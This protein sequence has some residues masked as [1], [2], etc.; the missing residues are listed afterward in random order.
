MVPAAEGHTK[1][2]LMLLDGRPIGLFYRYEN[3]AVRILFVTIGETDERNYEKILYKSKFFLVPPNTTEIIA[4]HR[5]GNLTYTV[6]FMGVS[7]AQAFEEILSLSL[8][9]I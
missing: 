5:E 6:S 2:V 8:I 4:L 3:G 1:Y 9:H 7:R